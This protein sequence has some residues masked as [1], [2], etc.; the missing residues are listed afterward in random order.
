MADIEF[1]YAVAESVKLEMT[2]AYELAMASAADIELCA[3][4]IESAWKM[5]GCEAFFE[6]MRSSVKSYRGLAE[7]MQGVIKRLD[8]TADYF[9]AVE[10]ARARAVEQAN[11]IAAQSAAQ[12]AARIQADANERARRQQE[13]LA[14]YERRQRE[15]R[16]RYPDLDSLPSVH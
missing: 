8:Q 13:E 16:E 3:N 7:K 1:D 14:E 12:K 6:F 9:R 5:D 11:A 2:K 4:N 15:L 10:Q